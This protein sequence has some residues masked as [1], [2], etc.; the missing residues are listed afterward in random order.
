MNEKID[1]QFLT[2][3]Y[4][5]DLCLDQC[6]VVSSTGRSSYSPFA[7]MTIAG[8]ISAGLIN[9]DKEIALI[10]FRCTGCMACTEFCEHNIDV[11]QALRGTRNILIQKGFSPIDSS[12]LIYNLSQEFKSIKDILGK[13]FEPGFMAVMLPGKALLQDHPDSLERI[14]RLFEGLG[15]EYIGLDDEI[16]QLCSGYELWAAGF[17]EDFA[18]H[19]LS[20]WTK[21][22]R[23]KII[24]TPSPMEEY[25]LKFIYP[26]YNVGPGPQIR[27]LIEVILPLIE[28]KDISPF[29]GHIGFHDCT[30]SGR[31]MGRYEEPRRILR[32]ILGIGP[33][34]LR[35]NRNFAPSCGFGGAYGVLFEQD[36]K[37][38]AAQI[39]RMAQDASIKTLIT[40]SP[41][42]LSL[43]KGP[44]DDYDIEVKLL[45]DL[46]YEWLNQE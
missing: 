34:E 11:A 19:A 23:F 12:D 20:V 21:L 38:I 39:L 9:I 3:M 46:I 14:F 6:P 10:P 45:S 22:R 18:K 7:K 16:S 40:E 1:K 42:C 35:R 4:C 28:V 27:S 36:A 30:F 17:E 15:I 33:L 13:W 25:T 5:P 26:G 44:G 43:L 32:K 29:S 8:L 24:V 31:Y 37:K 2:C 41:E